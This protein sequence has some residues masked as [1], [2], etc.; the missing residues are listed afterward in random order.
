MRRA[1]ALAGNGAPQGRGPMP[2]PRQLRSPSLLAPLGVLALL[3]VGGAALLLAGREGDDRAA[4]PAEAQLVFAEF[5]AT[6]DRIYLAA[7][8]DLEERSV[9]AR[10]PHASGW[11]LTPAR[12]MAG[13]LVAFTVLPRDAPPRRDSP[14]ELWLLDVATGEL[15]RL[16]RDADL[17][18]APVL[19]REGRYLVYRSSGLDGSQAL[20][21][22]DLASRARR[23]LLE[24][25]TDFGLFP[26]AFA[27]DGALLFAQL[28]N[29]GTDLH[30]VAPDGSTAPLVHASD[31][32]ARDWRLSPDGRALSY[33]APEIEAERVVQRLHV[34]A[35]DGSSAPPVE[36]SAGIAGEQFS[37]V[38]TPR[39]DGITFGQ[40]AGFAAGAPALTLPLGGA[41]PLPLDGPQQG[42]DAPLGWSDDGRY[43]AT[44]SFDGRDASAPGRESLVVIATA[45]GRETVRADRELIFIGWLPDA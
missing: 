25:A 31:H 9:I 7:A 17:L 23:T 43:L 26:V 20:V 27:R 8:N 11:A 21:R 3:I 32:V 14:A 41:P 44:R 13:T 15:T 22:V 5:G 36:A 42:F 30:R 16:A 39:G 28:S 33:L 4:A 45:G 34:V 40:E 2:L 1:S 38:W 35:L 18:A 29:G 10:V 37:P 24:V 12:E 6:E 19:D